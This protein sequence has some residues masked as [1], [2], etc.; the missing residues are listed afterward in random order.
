M[1]SIGIYIQ[2]L[3][4]K[5][6]TNCGNGTT[7]IQAVMEGTSGTSYAQYYLGINKVDMNDLNFAL[8]IEGG[9]LVF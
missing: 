3:H 7:D 4:G 2:L 5:I 8:T 1:I 6:K 9:H